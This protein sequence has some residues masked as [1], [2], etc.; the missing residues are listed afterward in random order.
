MIELFKEAGYETCDY[1][2]FADVYVINTCTVTNMS[3]RKSRQILRRAK[4]INPDAIL[5]V[6]GCYVQVAKE[7]LEKLPEIDILLGTNDR[8]NIVTCVNDFLDKKKIG[9]VSIV[10]DIM[11][12][13]EYVEWGSTAYTDK[14]RAEIK[15]QD[16]CDRFCT[17]CI[18][19]YARGPVRSRNI[20]ERYEEALK[21]AMTG[22]KE[23][24]VTGIHISSYGKDLKDDIKLI[25]VLERLNSIEKI[26]RI[27][28]GSLEPLIITEEFVHRLSKLD[29]VCN[30]FHLSLQSGCDETLKRMNRRYTVDEF[31]TIVKL[32]RDNIPEVALTTDVIVGFPGETEEEFMETVNFVKKVKFFQIHVFPYSKR[33]GTVAARM[34]DLNGDIKRKRVEILEKINEKLQKKYINKCKKTLHSVLIEEKE[35]QYYIGHAENYIKCYIKAEKLE[36]NT[37][38]TVKLKKP[39][40]DGALAVVKNMKK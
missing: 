30:H 7:E 9:K 15:I 22:I 40:I 20:N 27:R 34:K 23:L 21:L 28:L 19:P 12:K 2:E 39:Y 36:T 26:K 38:V 14:G 33:E 32:L 16:G 4:E 18:I 17:Y 24:V 29:K 31:R 10:N 11:K 3:E 25:D 8:K 37:F 5:C 1:E 13:Q 35:G 6:V